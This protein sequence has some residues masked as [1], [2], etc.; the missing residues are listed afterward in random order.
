MAT[1]IIARGLGA[2]AAAS[3][4]LANDR[5]DHLANGI[6]YRGAVDYYDDLAQITAQEGDAY[7]VKYQGSSGTTPDGTEYVWGEYDNTLQWIA[8]GPDLS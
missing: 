2:G 5:L 4:A 7:T 1:D 8:I 6:V 3:A